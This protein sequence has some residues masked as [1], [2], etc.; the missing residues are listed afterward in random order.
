[1]EVSFY[2]DHFEPRVKEKQ[3]HS[4]PRAKEEKNITTNLVRKRREV[5]GSSRTLNLMRKRGRASIH[6]ESQTSCEREREYY[7]KVS[8]RRKKGVSRSSGTQ[9]LVR[10]KVRVLIHEEFQTLYER[11]KEYQISQLLRIS[12]GREFELQSSSEILNLTQNT[13]RISSIIIVK[14]L[15]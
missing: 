9:N 15:E 5:I 12:G 3:N 11:G 2:K 7:S 4:I 6:R 10:K 1:M 14:N 8:Y 13:D